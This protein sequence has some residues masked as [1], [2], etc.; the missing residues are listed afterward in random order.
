MA[1]GAPQT[2]GQRIRQ[3]RQRR[4]MTLAQVA[5]EDFSRAFLNQV[6]MG[7]SQPS[8]RVLRII[9]S[10]LGAPVEYL[11]EGGSST[12]EAEL[13]VERARLALLAGRPRQALELVVPALGAA[14]PLGSEARLCQAE[15]LLGVGQIEQARRL[16]QAEE[17][18]L[19][20]QGDEG[21]LLR[22]RR[23]GSG[24]PATMDATAHGRLAER[25]LRAGRREL[26]LEHFRA[27]RILR[28]A[29]AANTARATSGT[30]A[31]PRR[32]PAADR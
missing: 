23:L 29:E 14:G 18:V 9:A 6:E 22:L 3:V 32:R 30:A 4:G 2:L 20:E 28:E 16:L 8:T 12:L 1:E 27:A 15:A 17:P 25:A 5:G 26:A 21:R 7:R 31:D 13:A 19:R 11:L 24:H 10:R